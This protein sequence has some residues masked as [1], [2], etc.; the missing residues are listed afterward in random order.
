M[1]HLK[2]NE[3]DLHI[4]QDN[5][6][7]ITKE[8]DKNGYDNDKYIVDTVNLNAGDEQ[9][10]RIKIDETGGLGYNVYFMQKVKMR[11]GKEVMSVI[12]TIFI[13]ND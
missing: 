8:K 7:S 5:I 4:T 9:I 13:Y 1:K 6:T 10:D 3:I 2:D 12:E 11:D